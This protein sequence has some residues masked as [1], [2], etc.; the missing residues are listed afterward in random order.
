MNSNLSL[1]TLQNQNGMT[2]TITNLGGR[3][4]SPL[5]PDKDGVQRDVVL[6][7]ENVEEEE[8][9]ADAPELYAKPDDWWDQNDVASRCFEEVQ[10]LTKI[11]ES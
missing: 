1:F 9:E 2:A 11:L 8:A 4:V 5:V 7:F 10:E 6:G 3:I